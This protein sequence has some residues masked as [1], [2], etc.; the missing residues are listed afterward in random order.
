MRNPSTTQSYRGPY[1]DSS[2]LWTDQLK[3]DVDF[4]NKGSNVFYIDIDSYF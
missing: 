3:Q 2:N 1:S 4:A